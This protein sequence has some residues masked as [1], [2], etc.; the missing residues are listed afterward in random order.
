MAPAS[1]HPR[2]V[3]VVSALVFGGAL[4]WCGSAAAEVE[5]ARPENTVSMCQDGRDNDGDS[6]ADCDDQDC[7]IFA[8]CLELAPAPAPVVT[9]GEL[10]VQPPPREPRLR[11]RRLRP[12]KRPSRA[13]KL[14]RIIGHATFWPGLALTGISTA[15]VYGS[16]RSFGR[17]DPYGTMF[18]MGGGALM[19][20]GIGTGVASI[21]MRVNRESYSRQ[22][23]LAPIVG[24]ELVGI[25]GVVVF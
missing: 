7:E 15:I 11:T 25:G 5:T 3:R 19:V 21:V 6:H 14:L 9:T 1:K 4:L 2:I 12:P 22:F 17:E 18:A 23:A 8:I 24:D 16:G 13:P 10:I 20:A